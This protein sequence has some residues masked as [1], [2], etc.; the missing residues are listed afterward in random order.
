MYVC[1]LKYL[2][3]IFSI[4]VS[5]YDALGQ[6][7]RHYTTSL[8]AY[9]AAILL[10]VLRHWAASMYSKKHSGV[11]FHSALCGEHVKPYYLFLFTRF[12]AAFA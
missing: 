7:S 2:Y 11:S 12:D 9:L 6:L 8:P 1:N 4:G 3:N 5:V 10:L